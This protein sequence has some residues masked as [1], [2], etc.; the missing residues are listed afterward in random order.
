MVGEPEKQCIGPKAISNQK[1]GVKWKS[2]PTKRKWEPNNQST[3]KYGLEWD[4]QKSIKPTEVAQR[5][6]SDLKA[7]CGQNTLVMRLKEAMFGDV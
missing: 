4:V 2:F 3:R 5:L 1:R 6:F 7:A